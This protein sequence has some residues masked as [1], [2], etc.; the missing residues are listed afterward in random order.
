MAQATGRCLCGEVQFTV[1]DI[2]AAHHACHCAMCRRWG[3]GPM[4]AARVAAIEITAGTEHVRRYRSSDWADRAFCA[5]CGTHLY[6]YLR[7]GDSYYLS[8]GTFDDATPFR[9]V[10]E[11]YVDAQPPGYAFAG[12]LQRLTEADVI[13][14]LGGEPPGEGAG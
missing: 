3:S 1:T 13:G 7:P 11:I 10:G 6:Y 8:V 12:D 9:L 5:Q 4:F 14:E 2:E